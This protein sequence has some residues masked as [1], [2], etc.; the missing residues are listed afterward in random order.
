MSNSFN[1]PSCRLEQ[2]ALFVVYDHPS[3]FPHCYVV[4]RWNGNIPSREFCV[5]PTLEGARA[6]I[7]AHCANLGRMP[8]EDPVILEVWI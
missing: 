5:A 7:P 2:P 4:R 8:G 1:G 3:D 6:A